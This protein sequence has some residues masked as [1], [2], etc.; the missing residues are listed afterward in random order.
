MDNFDLKKFLV[1]N[2]LNKTTLTEA[3]Y[4]EFML[5]WM[6]PGKESN[7]VIS[8]NLKELF[9]FIDEKNIKSYIIKGWDGEKWDI[10]VKTS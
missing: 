9:N 2:K 8:K 1:E 5:E 7:T 10:L 6:V 3:K 4:N